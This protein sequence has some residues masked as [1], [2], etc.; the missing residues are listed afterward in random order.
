MV[1][2]SQVY[3]T[4]PVLSTRENIIVIADE[5]QRSQCGFTT[6]IPAKED[7]ALITFRFAKPLREVLP[8]A[9]FIN[10]PFR[11]A[12]FSMHIS[13]ETSSSHWSTMLKTTS[14]SPRPTALP[15]SRTAPP[16]GSLQTFCLACT[17]GASVGQVKTRWTADN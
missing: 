5:A 13:G 8:N 7:K 11:D 3:P 16:T 12:M 17:N 2:V 14:T 1:N 10:L 9:S 4:G 6:K 15:A